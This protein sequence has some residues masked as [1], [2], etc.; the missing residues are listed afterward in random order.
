MIVRNHVIITGNLGA[1][2]RVVHE[3][4]KSGVV[5]RLSLANS[6]YRY[7]KESKEHQ[8]PHVNWIPITAFAG[9]AKRVSRSLKKGDLVTVTGAIRASEY[10]DSI[11]KTLK[12]FEIIATDILRSEILPS[13]RAGEV[14]SFD[15]FKEVTVGGV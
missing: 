13:E 1:D 11:G 14:P 12:S 4:E 15:D 9:L 8:T 6:E 5:V 3:S 10:K 2:P 7:D